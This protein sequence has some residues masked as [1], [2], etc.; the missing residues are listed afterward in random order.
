[1]SLWIS[2][3]HHSFKL[4]LNKKQDS[5][6]SCGDL[7]EVLISLRLRVQTG[8]GAHPASYS[9]GIGGSF[10]SSKAVRA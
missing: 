8:S 2:Y 1:M 10:P 9:V 7:L 4:F 6:K 5:M 3:R